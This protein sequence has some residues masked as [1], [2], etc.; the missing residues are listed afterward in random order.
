MVVNN[1]IPVLQRCS[2]WT[3]ACAGGNRVDLGSLPTFK[4]FMT[5]LLT[6]VL[7]TTLFFITRVALDPSTS[8]TSSSEKD[9]VRIHDQIT[10][11]TRSYNNCG[12]ICQ[13]FNYSQPMWK[14][15]DP[16]VKLCKPSSSLVFVK[17]HKT[18]S[19]TLT[20]IVN[21]YGLARNLSFLIYSK[22]PLKGHFCQVA[23]TKPSDILPPIGVEPGDFDHYSNYDMAAVHIRL[24]PNLK[25]FTRFMNPRTRYITILRDPVDQWESAFVFFI[26]H[27][28]MKLKGLDIEQSITT[29]LKKPS[30]YWQ[31][32]PGQCKLFSKNGMAFDL[33]SE[34]SLHNLD[35]ISVESAVAFLDEKMDLVLIS[36]Y[37]DESLLLLKH[38]MCWDFEDILY[39]SANRRSSR[40][41]MSE[42]QKAKIRQWNPIDTILY[43]HFNR[44]LWKKIAAI[45][46]RFWKDLDYFRQL[47]QDFFT[48]CGFE[49]NATKGPKIQTTARNSSIACRSVLQSDFKE[50]I[51]RQNIYKPK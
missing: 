25:F 4:K 19:T 42:S 1:D 48:M 33:L 21:R 3:C 31:K 12:I 44:T 32:F 8:M 5:A 15:P 27:T 20:K 22:D 11:H 7:P 36:D 28:K 23:P 35:N 41:K 13:L 34:D 43:E 37:M 2:A 9:Q 30:Y 6:I 16:A 17:T 38:L 51:R 49:V 45:G 26:C 24:F 46:P 39:V 47:K 40:T 50:I 14:L 10:I 18:G 29:F